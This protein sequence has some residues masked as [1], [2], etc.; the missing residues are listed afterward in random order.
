[1]PFA[2]FL[3]RLTGQFYSLLS[4]SFWQCLLATQVETQ[5]YP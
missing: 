2:L 5:K 1:V 3:E 4:S